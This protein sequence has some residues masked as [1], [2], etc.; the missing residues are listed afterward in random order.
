LIV[1]LGGLF[2]ELASMTFAPEIFSPPLVLLPATSSAA[3]AVVAA[4]ARGDEQPQIRRP[5]RP[6]SSCEQASSA[7]SSS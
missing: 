5:V 2:I 7:P 6:Q 3:A 1:P 4:A